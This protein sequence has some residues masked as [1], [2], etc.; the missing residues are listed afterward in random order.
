MDAASSKSRPRKMMRV[1]T[2]FTGV[3]AAT[4]G[5]TQVANA[6]EIRPAGAHDIRPGHAARPAG[7]VSGSIRYNEACGNQSIDKTWLHVSTNTG[8][9]ILPY[10]SYCFGFKGT[11]VSP[12]G[13]GVNYECGGNN[14][15]YLIGVNGGRSKS[16][17]F[18]PGTGYATLKW[19]HLYEL[20]INSWTGTDTCGKPPN[21]F[22]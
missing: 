2:I 21:W 19:S 17:H 12:P 18:G 9:S 5:V 3:A 20:W 10:Q 4:A 22:E 13:I 7:R 6:Q 16:F 14:H 1:A 11:Y 8:S 15:G